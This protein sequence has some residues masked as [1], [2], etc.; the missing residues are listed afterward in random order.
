MKWKRKDINFKILIK[1]NNSNKV[2][3]S[4]L[5]YCTKL[6]FWRRK[7]LFYCRIFKNLKLPFDIVLNKLLGD[8]TYN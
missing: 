4:K 5:S 8:K 6:F 3:H 7:K 1:E 2:C